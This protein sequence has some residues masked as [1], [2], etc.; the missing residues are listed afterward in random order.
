MKTVSKLF[1]LV[2]FTS[3]LTAQALTRSQH[4]TA[5]LAQFLAALQARW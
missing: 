5:R 2:A 3:S 4:D 1:V